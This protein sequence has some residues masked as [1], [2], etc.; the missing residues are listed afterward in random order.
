MSTNYDVVKWERRK[1]RTHENEQL[2]L[3][4]RVLLEYSM[5]TLLI[6][7][8]PESTNLANGGNF[9]HFGMMVSQDLMT[10]GARPSKP[11]KRSDASLS[12]PDYFQVVAKKV[13]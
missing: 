1:N 13:V 6:R 9:Q 10:T 7:E 2:L 5:S 12:V 11:M 8:K 3:D 4:E